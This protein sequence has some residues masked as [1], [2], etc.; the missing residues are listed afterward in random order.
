MIELPLD[1]APGT[2]VVNIH[3]IVSF[4]PSAGSGT[5]IVMRD[6]RTFRTRADYAQVR[7]AMLT[8]RNQF[9]SLVP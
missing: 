6:G 8:V 1:E 2:R 3:D 9:E 5:L 4:E 7:A